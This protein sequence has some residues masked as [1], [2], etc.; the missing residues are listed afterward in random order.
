MERKS[1]RAQMN[2][3]KIMEDRIS[4]AANECDCDITSWFRQESKKD[5]G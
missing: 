1:D 2:D 4:Y 3:A 5:L